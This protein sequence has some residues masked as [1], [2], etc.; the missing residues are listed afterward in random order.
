MDDVTLPCNRSRLTTDKRGR[1]FRS[2][3]VEAASPTSGTR[4]QSKVVSNEN[5]CSSVLVSG[6]SSTSSTSPRGLVSSSSLSSR[7]D[8]FFFFLRTVGNPVRLAFLRLRFRS[9]WPPVLLSSDSTTLSPLCC[10][11]SLTRRATDSTW[12]RGESISVFVMIEGM[13]WEG[14]CS[15]RS[16]V[17]S[18]TPGGG[19]LVVFVRCSEFDIGEIL[20]RRPSR[21]FFFFVASEV[22]LESVSR[23]RGDDCTDL[24]LLAIVRREDD[25]VAVVDR[26]K[27]SEVVSSKC[28]FFG[29]IALFA[30]CFDWLHLFD[31]FLVVSS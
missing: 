31:E 2:I 20:E 25:D 16:T 22:F 10:G 17:G 23:S 13:V 29:V 3:K 4:S 21:R 24:L 12:V 26:S 19:P 8:C 14:I 9:K 27:T 11:S 28:R 18:K 5:D 7:V 30:G 1:E 15:S 6:A